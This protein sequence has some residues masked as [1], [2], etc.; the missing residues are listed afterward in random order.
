MFEK[1]FGSDPE[2]PGRRCKLDA[3]TIALALVCWDRWPRRDTGIH[4][5][6]S[7][8]REAPMDDIASFNC[9]IASW[10]A[11]HVIA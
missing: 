7:R 10:C 1:V 6:A 9:T 5:R 3:F 11:R 8:Y 4:D 2:H